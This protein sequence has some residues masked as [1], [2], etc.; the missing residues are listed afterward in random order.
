MRTASILGRINRD[1]AIGNNVT[2][3]FD[4]YS[5]KVTFLEFTVLVVVLQTGQNMGNIFTM[6]VNIRGVNQNIIKINCHE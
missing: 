3:V 1:G 6:H 4:S 5:S 2:K